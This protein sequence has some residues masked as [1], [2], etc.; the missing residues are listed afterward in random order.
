MNL[1]SRLHNWIEN[2]NHEYFDLKIG[3]QAM[4]DWK[5][6]ILKR[7]SMLMKKIEAW[8]SYGGFRVAYTMWKNWWREVVD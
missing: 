1:D 2:F 3:I 5:R 8:R 4:R 6:M 7:E